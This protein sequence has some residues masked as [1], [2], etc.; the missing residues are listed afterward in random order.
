MQ[1]SDLLSTDISSAHSVSRGVLGRS[2]GEGEGHL[3]RND[4][5]FRYFVTRGGE[6]NGEGQVMFK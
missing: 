4:A 5:R 1:L 6:G 2:L 3:S